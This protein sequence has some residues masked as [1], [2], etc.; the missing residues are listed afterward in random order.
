MPPLF[1]PPK[2]KQRPRGNSLRFSRVSPAAALRA[3]HTTQLEAVSAA[4]LLTPGDDEERD[5]RSPNFMLDSMSALAG[6]VLTTPTPAPS[7]GILLRRRVKLARAV[8]EKLARAVREKLARTVRASSGRRI[9]A[10]NQV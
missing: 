3:G 7:R 10:V 5:W 9:L 1:P 2:P 8:R 6:A 4:I